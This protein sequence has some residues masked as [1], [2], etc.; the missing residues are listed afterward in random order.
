[1]TLPEMSKVLIADTQSLIVSGMRYLLEKI[2]HSP[3]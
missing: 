1:M 2:L 3:S